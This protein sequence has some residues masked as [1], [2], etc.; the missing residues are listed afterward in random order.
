[1]PQQPPS[2]VFDNLD[3]DLFIKVLSYTAFSEL[4]SLFCSIKL[5]TH[6]LIYILGPFFTFFIPVV[7]VAQ[8]VSWSAPVVV[9]S[10]VYFAF[11]SAFCEFHGGI[12]PNNILYVRL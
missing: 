4:T 5:L 12:N 11:I 8:G 3:L 2:Q 9:G 1:M 10:C 6:Y 7:Y